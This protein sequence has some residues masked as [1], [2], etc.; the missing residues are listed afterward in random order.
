M[1]ALKSTLFT[2]L[3]L[4]FAMQGFAQAP[5]AAKLA[6]DNKD[7]AKAKKLIDEVCLNEKHAAKAKTWLY[8]GMIYAGIANDQQG[9]Y[10][11]LQD[12]TLAITAY[13]AI[14]KCLEMEPDNKEAI[15]ERKDRIQPAL[16]NAALMGYNQGN[17]LLKQEKEAEAKPKFEICIKN[18]NFAS[19]ITP[20]DTLCPFLSMSAGYSGK[21][22][23]AFITASNTLVNHKMTK[24]KATYCE[25]L[26]SYYY[27]IAKD[28]KMALETAQ[29]GLTYGGTPYLQKLTVQL[30]NEGGNADE[31]I[32]TLQDN[33]KKN[34][35]D[36]LNYFNLGVLYEKTK[37]T[38][39][40]IQAYEKA[41]TISAL[42]E[43]IYNIGALY[44]NDGVEISKVVND[45]PQD[46]YNRKGRAEEAKVDAEFKKALPY[47][48]KLY[49]IDAK[50]KSTLNI[51]I[52]IYQKLKM[53][54]KADKIQK[55]RDALGD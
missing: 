43:A 29:K 20:D 13:E 1:K 55:E 8:K 35:N 33:I 4:F 10:K 38:N 18:A 31:A 39:E 25:L 12:G 3:G 34:P 7:Y 21:N 36:A 37:K 22:Y 19:L 17:T 44:F 42:P 23:P 26:A 40:A 16:V 15:A 6:Y 47:F 54:D 50:E 9:I 32:K 51:L 28:N 5:A 24:D 2:T 41:I 45:M 30:F 11:D 53:K 52:Q 14:A 49:L 27:S 46:E 48:E